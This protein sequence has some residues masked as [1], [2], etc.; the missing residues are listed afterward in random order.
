[1]NEEE[2]TA[3]SMHEMRR[4]RDNPADRGF[5]GDRSELAPSQP[6]IVPGANHGHS[7]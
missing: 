4:V 5:E 1:M 3:N 2:C 7:L 6:Q